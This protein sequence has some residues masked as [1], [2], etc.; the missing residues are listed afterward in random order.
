MRLSALFRVRVILLIL[1]GALLLRYGYL[2]YRVSTG[3]ARD[4]WEVPSILYGRPATIRVGDSLE[5][6]RLP[7]RLAR[8]SYRKVAGTPAKPGTWSEEPDLIRIRTRDFRQGETDHLG[9]GAVIGIGDGRV[10]SLATESGEAAEAVRLEPEEVARILGPRLESRRLV[11][12]AAIPKT[13]QDAVLAAE[14][15]RFYSHRGIDSIGILR[16]LATNLRRMRLVQGGSTITQQLAKNFFLTPKRSIWRKIREVELAFL[17]EI[18]Y[19]KAEILEAYLNKIYLGQEGP[20]GIYGV[21]EAARFY[22]SKGVGELS[23]GESA[24]IAGI[25]SSPNRFSPLRRI[26]VAKDRRD[27]VLGRM[28]KLGMIDEAQFR[29]ASRSPVRTNP[30]RV[31][32][33]LAEYY[34]DYIRRTAGEALGDERLYQTGYRFYTSLDPAHQA[35][36]ETAVSDGLAELDRGNREKEPLE[37]ALVAVDVVTGEMT[38]MVGGR[39]Y[40]ETQFN[41]AADARRQPGSAFKPFVLL[42]AMRQAVEGKGKVTLGS[43]VSGEPVA[44]PIPGGTWE[45]ANYEGTA[46]GAMT[47]RGMIENSVNTAAVRLALDTGLKEVAD[48]ARAAGVASTLLPVP[49]LALGSFEV[50]PVELAYAYATLASGGTRFEPFALHAVVGSDGALLVS[51]KPFRKDGAV[52]PRAAYLVTHALEGV[53]DRGTARSARDAGIDFPAA[54]KTGTTDD[55]RDSWFV[56]YTPDLVCAVWVGRDSGA[57]SGLS[58][59][60]GALR[61]WT[62]FMKAVYPAG[63][64]RAFAV[65]PGIATAEIDPESGLLATTACPQGYVEAFPDELVPTETCPLH[66][67]HPLVDTVRR[68]F[69]GIGEFFR[70][71]FR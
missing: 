12:L 36:A 41:R 68:G 65:P 17:L 53:L 4:A 26:E 15:A 31:P 1:G 16:A 24:L 19:A 35:A 64:Q 67:V 50:T 62:R 32:V 42:A 29:K 14:D 22:F 21:E 33:N 48:A 71:L 37:A 58:G 18:R 11:P 38:A 43:P 34:V 66:P 25:I 5:A 57:A 28:R 56:G 45:P 6:L 44:V 39:G 30:R 63:S 2:Y 60:A 46:Y 20:R 70:N 9:V 40:G 8:L 13:L 47:V 52:D 10:A 23:I 69:R 7:S 54:G 27:W 3:F 55:F 49:S 59:A 61:I 51:S